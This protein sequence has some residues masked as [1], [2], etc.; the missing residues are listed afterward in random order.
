MDPVEPKFIFTG[1]DSM[2]R[3]DVEAQTAQ[4]LGYPGPSKTK[5]IAQGVDNRNRMYI[6]H[7]NK[8]YRTDEALTTSA[9]GAAWTEIQNDFPV[10]AALMDL[11]VNPMN[12]NELYVTYSG[13]EAGKK[14]YYSS[15][16]GN[17]GTWANVS[18]SL[19]NVS[20]N[21]IELHHTG[22][23]NHAVYLGTDLGVYHRQD[24]FSEW[25]YF[26]NNL[27][28]CPV[29]DL[30]INTASSEIVAATTGRGVWKSDLHST[31]PP[32]VVL[33]LGDP[34]GG[35]RHYSASINLT[36][37]AVY[38][39]SF[40]TKITYQAGLYVDL[41]PGFQVIAPAFFHARTGDCPVFYEQD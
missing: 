37:T 3:L 28:S 39:P 16:S 32:S 19:P 2:W 20:I 36:S 17:A 26:G 23:D 8:L 33:M 7:G 24:G 4:W 11:A 34:S 41:L 38:D 31:C 15:N 27:P 30:Y 10:S 5:A 18:G 14:V 35:V 12:A 29:S 6:I 13:I 21:C 40:S 1:K 9:G 25:I 22:V